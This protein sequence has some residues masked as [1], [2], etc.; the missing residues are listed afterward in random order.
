MV[1][2]DA[3][4]AAELRA[5]IAEHDWRYHV[6]DAPTVA[7]VEYD[8]LYAELKQLE[9]RHPE[10][11][12]PESPTQRVGGAP[13]SGFASVAHDPPLLSLD[14][15]YD[16]A[17]VREWQQRLLDH[18]K[19]SE[20]PSALVA[21]PKLDGLSCRLVYEQGRLVLGATRGSGEVG[22]DVTANVRT[23]R[24][25]P[26]VLRGQPPARLD[27]RG[28]VVVPRAAFEALNRALVAK[29]EKS[30]ANPRN[31]AAGT[32]RQLDPQLVAA[33]PLEFRVWALGKVEGAPL[34]A[35]H[36][37]ALEWL[38]SLGLKTV[39]A[40]QAIGDLETV[41]SHYRAL[42][43]RRDAFP[44][45]LD[46]MVLKV[47]RFDVQQRL[48]F[49]AKSP[50]F[51][52]AFKF[53]AR[54]ATTRIAAIRVQVGRTG[55]LT[56]VAEL[57]PVALSGVTITN[58]TLHNRDECARL[59]VRV[60]DTV[61]IERSGDVIPKV[62]QVVESAPR[63]A[64]PWRFPE[65]C[66]ACG[67][68]AEQEGDFVAVRCPNE[69][70]PAR[71]QKRLEHLVGRNALD[72]D[73]LGERLLQQL[74]EKG[75]VRQPADLFQLPDAPLLELERMG[76]KSVAAL[77]AALRAAHRR[78]LAAFLYALGIPEIGETAAEQI[79]HHF[80]TLERVRAATA[81]DVEAIHGLGPSAAASLVAAFAPESR[82]AAEVDALLAAGVTPLPAVRASGALEGKTFLF[83]GTLPTLSRAEAEARVKAQGG[84][85]LSGVSKRLSYL[86]VGDAPGSKLKKANELGVAVLDE[87]Q[88]LALL[89][90][91]PPAAAPGAAS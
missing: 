91:G 26:L 56:P 70:C 12:V 42:L 64:E 74:V 44:I 35:S 72:V 29:G 68:K 65:S 25:V 37:A 10:L 18:L 32:L 90:S 82:S 15:T 8:R 75:L 33:R 67:T 53:P 61:L 38:E 69:Q 50:R 28:E 39:R 71:L 4:R 1:D 2:A 6:L 84:T 66:P 60:G 79:A 3:R 49:T 76:E 59:G 23:I 22:E 19:V 73:G 30:Y 57:E 88:F 62:V 5:L 77:Q 54:Q 45:E 16:E 87:A 9:E 14:N 58:V 7:D 46:G 89:A 34:P 27:V 83:T 80:E 51:A 85:L 52:R 47:D 31:L 24:S 11:R 43:E 21:E 20:L 81:A 40:D 55:T 17:E 48:G 13:A 36:S 41:L 78:P 86:V 63:G